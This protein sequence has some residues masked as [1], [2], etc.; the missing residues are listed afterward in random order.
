MGLAHSLYKVAL[1]YAE[2]QNEFFRKDPPAIWRVRIGQSNQLMTL[3]LQFCEPDHQLEL[4]SLSKR[5]YY[6]LVPTILN[7]IAIYEQEAYLLITNK[8][9]LKVLDKKKL[10]WREIDVLCYRDRM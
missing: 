3:I 2:S 5:I 8:Q 7:K 6:K 1:N 10:K 4:S 9:S